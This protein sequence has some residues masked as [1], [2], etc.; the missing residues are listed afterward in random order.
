MKNENTPQPGDGSP[1][2][3]IIPAD[4]NVY[5]SNVQ[6]GNT[7]AIVMI[8]ALAAGIE[9][10]ASKLPDAAAERILRGCKIAERVALIIGKNARDLQGVITMT[11]AACAD[12]GVELP[13][14]VTDPS[15]MLEKL[16]DEG[17]S[18]DD[19][20]GEWT[21]K[22]N[23]LRAGI[24]MSRDS[25]AAQEMAKDPETEHDGD[26]T[27]LKVD[28][29]RKRRAL[30]KLRALDEAAKRKKEQS[31]TPPTPPTPPTWSG[32]NG[33]KWNPDGTRDDGAT[34]SN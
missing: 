12:V 13:D 34:P 7:L 22:E 16:R 26:V 31:Q 3:G 20:C 29:E 10:E 33:A 9:K 4:L 8:A 25:A 21:E 2:I 17:T 23:S 1:F 24:V 28:G 14:L 32:R 6:E 11:R 18:T 5:L 27:R 19:I 15:E 30:E